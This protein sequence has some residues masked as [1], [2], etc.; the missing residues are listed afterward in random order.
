MFFITNMYERRFNDN[1]SRHRLDAKIAPSRPKP[2]CR[3][4]QSNDVPQ[5]SEPLSRYHLA[6]ETKAEVPVIGQ[7]MPPTYQDSFFGQ[8]SA[9]TDSQL[10]LLEA[11]KAVPVIVGIKP[12]KRTSSQESGFFTGGDSD[13]ASNFS[14]SA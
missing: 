10:S 9:S 6:N 14:V 11:Q 1:M 5:K 12:F 13:V 4:V 8:K 7:Q 2:S 3:F